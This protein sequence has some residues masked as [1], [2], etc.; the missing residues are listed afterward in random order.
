MTPQEEYALQQKRNAADS[1]ALAIHMAQYRAAVFLQ[2]LCAAAGL[3]GACWKGW[4]AILLGAAG[5]W[6]FHH[7]KPPPTERLDKY[8]GRGSAGE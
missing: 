8:T 7:A 4:P 5:V 1:G 2:L 6:L 3:I